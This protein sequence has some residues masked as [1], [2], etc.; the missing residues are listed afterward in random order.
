MI[1]SVFF[2]IFLLLSCCC[3]L[4]H[5][6]SPVF[7]IQ[8][9]VFVFFLQPSFPRSLA[10]LILNYHHHALP[11]FQFLSLFSSSSFLLLFLSFSSSSFSPSS[12]FSSSSSYSNYIN[13]MISS[14]LLV[15]SWART[16]SIPAHLFSVTKKYGL[17]K[18]L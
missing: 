12:L 10:L 17:V 13:V 9:S 15:I 2:V 5:F 7:P 1:S 11:L 4:F 3:F 18:Y 14:L 8:Q 16:L 6:L